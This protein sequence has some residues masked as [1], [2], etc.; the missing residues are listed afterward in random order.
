MEGGHSLCADL[1]LSHL[2]S[3]HR[4][5]ARPLPAALDDGYEDTNYTHEALPDGTDDLSDEE[6]TAGLRIPEGTTTARLYH[7]PKAQAS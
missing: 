2:S 6:K 7:T 4:W 1:G 5:H 3:V